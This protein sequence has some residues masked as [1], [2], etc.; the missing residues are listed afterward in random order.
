MDEETNFYKW[1][2][3]IVHD[4]SKKPKTPQNLYTCS[5]C[6][7]AIPFS[8]KTAWNCLQRELDRCE[9]ISTQRE[10]GEDQDKVPS[11]EKCFENS[12]KLAARSKSRSQLEQLRTKMQLFT[13]QMIETEFNFESVLPPKMDVKTLCVSNSDQ[14]LSKMREQVEGILTEL[15]DQVEAIFAN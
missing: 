5:E 3:S 8:L 11:L 6:L 4:V 9:D 13:Q 14:E 7:D 1:I 12:M 10:K 2:T 15:C